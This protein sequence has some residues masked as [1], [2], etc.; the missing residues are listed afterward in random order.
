MTKQRTPS[1]LEIAAVY[2][3]L[4]TLC[5]APRTSRLATRVAHLLI[6]G[7]TTEGKTTDE[8]SRDTIERL[9][10]SRHGRGYKA[11]ASYVEHV[12]RAIADAAAVNIEGSDNDELRHV[13]H[14]H[15]NEGVKLCAYL[16]LHS[17]QARLAGNIGYAT[18]LESLVDYIHKYEL[19][20][21]LRW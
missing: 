12:R 18:Q 14:Y 6:M 2:D 8:H 4:G 10:M 19:P 9:R 13:A 20:A 16:T 7:I 3:I 15:T 17:R 11:S 5:Q 21:E 1:D